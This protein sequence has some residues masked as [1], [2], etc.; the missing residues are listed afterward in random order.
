[1]GTHVAGETCFLPPQKH[2]F[3]PQSL[4]PQE[5]GVLLLSWFWLT[6]LSLED[7]SFE[8]EMST[9]FW[10]ATLGYPKGFVQ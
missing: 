4:H 6:S 5:G 2:V 8:E 1:M 9:G 10:N 3:T 7:P